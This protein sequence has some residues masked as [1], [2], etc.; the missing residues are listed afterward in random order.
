MSEEN[1]RLKSAPAMAAAATV[2]DDGSI[3]PSVTPSPRGEHAPSPASP[4]K[5]C[6]FC[7]STKLRAKD[8]AEQGYK[9]GA[10]ECE[11]C[12]ARG[13]EVRTGY[14]KP[15]KWRPAAI[16]EWNRRTPAPS[17]AT[18]ESAIDKAL[19]PNCWDLAM[20]ADTLAAARAELASLRAEVERLRKPPSAD[21]HIKR[22]SYGEPSVEELVQ[23]YIR[24]YNKKCTAFLHKIDALDSDAQAGIAAVRAEMIGANLR[25]Y[26]GALNEI[27]EAIDSCSDATK[28]RAEGARLCVLT[29]NAVGDEPDEHARA[30]YSFATNVGLFLD[31]LRTALAEKEKAG[32]DVEGIARAIDSELTEHFMSYAHAD[33][34]MHDK[35][36][37]REVVRDALRTALGA[38]E[39]K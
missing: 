34:V 6:P 12:S 8:D 28:L 29:R 15:E 31:S 30:C 38:K 25:P 3:A 4:V 9:W 11:E 19:D 5:P 32:V 1:R 27:R 39:T 37:R 18:G 33:E 14:D 13:P 20:Q 23:V 16:E 21:P 24:A 7:A 17:P 10:I 36:S 22:G 35:R 26:E 2:S